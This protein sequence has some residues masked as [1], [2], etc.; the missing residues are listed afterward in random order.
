MTNAVTG[1]SLV[2]GWLPVFGQETIAELEQ[3]L[4]TL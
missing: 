2:P 1:A 4:E 3:A